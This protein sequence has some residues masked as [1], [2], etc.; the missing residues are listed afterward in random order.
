M[1]WRAPI[2]DGMFT[3]M[4]AARPGKADLFEV[5]WGGVGFPWLLLIFLAS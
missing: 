1:F 5:G 2:Q 3:G 4:R